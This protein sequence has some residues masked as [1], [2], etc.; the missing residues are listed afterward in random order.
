MEPEAWRWIWLAA[1]AMFA[2]GELSS[3]G[4]FFLL[5]FAFGAAAAAVL[6][7]LGVPVAVE[8]GVFIVVSVAALAGFRQ[9]SHRLDRTEPT[10]GI[11]A[12]RLIGQQAKVLEAIDAQDLGTVRIDREEWRAE[13]GDG[14]PIPAGAAVKVVEVRGTRVVVFPA[15]GPNAPAPP[16]EPIDPP[17]EEQP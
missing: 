11:G 9:L 10:D 6:A 14:S 15:G 4:A 13:S 17:T 1:A 5:P 8:L 3:P 16:P 2:L 7:F 12:K